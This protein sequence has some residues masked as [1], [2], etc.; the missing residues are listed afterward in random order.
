MDLEA[1]DEYMTERGLPAWRTDQVWGWLA[2]G[3]ADFDEM[4]DLPKDLRSDLGDSFEISTLGVAGS[5]LS[6]DGT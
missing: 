1:L 5:A 4:T 6:K 3:A 2:R